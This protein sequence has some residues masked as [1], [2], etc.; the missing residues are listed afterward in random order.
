MHRYHYQVI[1]L[2]KTADPYQQQIDIVQEYS[3]LYKN[4]KSTPNQSV[5]KSYD[6]AIQI[7]SIKSNIFISDNRGP[8][9]K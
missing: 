9:E 5:C 6:G 2:Q 7:K 4:M 3:T 1:K 8:Y